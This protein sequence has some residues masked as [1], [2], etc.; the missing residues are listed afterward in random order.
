MTIGYL[1]LRPLPHRIAIQQ[2]PELLEQML[3]RPTRRNRGRQRRRHPSPTPA[4]GLPSNNTAGHPVA[5]PVP[6]T[7]AV[8]DTTVSSTATPVTTQPLVPTLSVTSF[9]TNTTTTSGHASGSSLVESLSPPRDD[10]PAPHSLLDSGMVLSYL[11]PG[12][13]FNLAIMHPMATDL[14]LETLWRRLGRFGYLFRTLPRCV[15][16]SSSLGI[17]AVRYF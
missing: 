5:A 12:T 4:Q 2:N 16:K 3:L 8:L 17:N 6:P 13:L 14:A 1:S 15:A 9:A 11:T 10:T 7:V